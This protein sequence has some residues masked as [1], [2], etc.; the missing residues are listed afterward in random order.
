MGSRRSWVGC[1]CSWG[2][3]VGVHGVAVGENDG[4]A[5]Q[6]R[7]DFGVGEPFGAVGKVFVIQDQAS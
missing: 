6:C 7:F 3:V 1:R 2:L 5:L 4:Q